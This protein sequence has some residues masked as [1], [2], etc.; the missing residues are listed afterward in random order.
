MSKLT[1]LFS[2]F[3][4]RDAEEDA[5]FRALSAVEGAVPIESLQARTLS[6][7]AGVVVAATRSMTTDSPRYEISIS[8]GTGEVVATFLGRREI[9][10][11][12]PGSVVSLTGRFCSAKSGLN[13]QNP[14]YEL[15]HRG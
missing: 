2:G 5:A 4:S 1:D 10:G 12:V 8:D 14:A 9:P 11:I 7:V 3:A 13:A 6:T 15:L